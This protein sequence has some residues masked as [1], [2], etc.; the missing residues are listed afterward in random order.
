MGDSEIHVGYKMKGKIMGFPGRMIQKFKTV[1]SNSKFL[2][3]V[4]INV[5]FLLLALL[6]CDMKYEVS[7]DFIMSTIMSGV[8]GECPNPHMI[9]VNIVLGYFLMPIYKVFPGISWYFVLQIIII[10]LSSIVVSFI[11]LEKVEK[12]K[13]ALLSIMLILFFVNDMYILMQFTKTAMFAIMSG[14]WLFLDTLFYGKNRWRILIGG[15]LCIVG[16][17]IRFYVIYLAGVFLIFIIGYEVIRMIRTHSDRRIL[18]KKLEKVVIGG[19]I[20]VGVSF[21]LNELDQYLYEQEESYA[22]FRQYGKA[23]GEIVDHTDHGYEAYAEELGKIGISENDYYMM[24]KWG[25][26]DNDFFTL[27]RM[28]QTA[29]IIKSYNRKQW[30]GWEAIIEKIQERKITNYPVF[31][32]NMILLLLGVFL[33]YEKWWISI[34][35][36]GIGWFYI[37]YFFIR[38]RT[39]YRT[40]FAVFLGVFLCSMYF[41]IEVKEKKIDYTEIKN[42]CGVLIIVLCIVKG[43]IYLPDRTYMNVTPYEKKSYVENIFFESWN[44]DARK[45]RKV[46]NKIECKSGLLDEFYS[47]S[48]KFYFLDFNTT[49]QTLYYEWSPWETIESEEYQ[50][51]YYLSGITTNFPEVVNKFE[52]ERLSN[53]LKALVKEQVYVVDNYNVDLKLNYLKEHYFPNA[54][55]ELIKEIDGYQIWKFYEK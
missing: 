15:S 50:N 48:E 20:L 35:V 7:D 31:M 19:C 14:S 33:N 44:Y 41:W 38:D 12:V 52:S 17:M 3:A 32:A 29:D 1:I 9:F 5:F 25:F 30:S 18:K 13:A 39:V 34:A 49:I 43:S 55:V 51:Y 10:F 8:Y 40:E 36:N 2:L 46:I 6:F 47:N 16:T 4:M 21:G 37:L 24:K 23:R 27:E 28:Q 11:L 22:F 53:P 54:R 42:K 45:Y 26:A